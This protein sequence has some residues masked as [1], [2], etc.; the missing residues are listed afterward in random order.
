MTLRISRG[1][2]KKNPISL[3]QLA[4]IATLQAHPG[5]YLR[6]D[7]RPASCIEWSDSALESDW[8]KGH[9]G[10]P[11]LGNVATALVKRGLLEKRHDQQARRIEYRLVGGGVN[12]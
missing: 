10:K 5:A 6:Y 7:L 2:H 1:G 3:I 4:I 9:G 8:R 12:G 11:V